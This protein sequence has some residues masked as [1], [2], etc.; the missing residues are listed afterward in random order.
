MSITTSFS[1]KTKKITKKRTYIP[2]LVIFIQRTSE[3]EDRQER[4]RPFPAAFQH[5]WRI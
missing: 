4:K 2:Q 5:I 3:P 1:K